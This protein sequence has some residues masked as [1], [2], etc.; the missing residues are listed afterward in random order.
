MKA[1]HGQTETGRPCRRNVLE[2]TTWCKYHKPETDALEAPY[3]IHRTPQV[4]TIREC[5]KGRVTDAV[6]ELTKG[7]EIFG[8]NKGQFSLL[9]VLLVVLER[10]GSA[11]VT[12]CTWTASGEQADGI[13]ELMRAKEIDAVRWVVDHS[14]PARQP[15]YMANLIARFGADAIRVTSTHAK[16]ITVVN[17]EWNIAIRSSMNL[18]T[19]RRFE[20]FEISDDPMLAGY[21]LT[22]VDEIFD[23][24]LV[25]GAVDVSDKF[26]KDYASSR[27][28][29]M[30]RCVAD[31]ADGERCQATA[32][33][34]TR[35]CWRH[36]VELDDARERNA[37]F[38]ERMTEY[39]LGST[40]ER[41][42]WLEQVRRGEIGETKITPRGDIQELPASL[43]D[44]I[45]ATKAAEQLLKEA[46]DN[47]GASTG[48]A[49]THFYSPDDGR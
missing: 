44:R 13:E 3:A 22:V 2:G 25:G 47:K 15:E 12:I 32:Y 37:E 23:S 29:E 24:P 27:E 21:L 43:A 40:E 20:Q 33:G 1:C 18:N 30:L 38:R 39:G 10:T 9:D 49:V 11:D 8:F 6:G 7:C 45:N 31:R 14:F 36:R 46:N 4:R 28:V 16:F 17:A 26:F 34:N 35:Y 42:A 41:V 19:N 5:F 48:A